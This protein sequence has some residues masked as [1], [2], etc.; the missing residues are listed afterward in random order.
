MP[1]A[2]GPHWI[3]RLYARRYPLIAIL[4]IVAI[5]LY[6]V[7]RFAA[8]APLSTANLPLQVA[9][10]LGGLPIVVELLIKLW[11]REFG[12]DLLAGISIVTSVLLHE[13]L[14]GTLVVLML[15]G[16]EAIESYAVRSAAGV[17][18]ALSKRM[19]SVAHRRR[20]SH[21]EEVPLDQIAADDEL[22]IFPHEICPVDGEVV[23]G[24]GVM[25]E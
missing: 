17:L 24:H 16:G 23:E 3:G 20:N 14:A 18:R 19:P 21:L 22:V 7:L 25:D 13:Y 5:A 8:G 15:S 1:A 9:L 12:S 11:Q 10:V 2:V 4:S 6:L